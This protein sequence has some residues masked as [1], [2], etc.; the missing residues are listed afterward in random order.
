MIREADLVI[1]NLTDDISVGGSQEMLIAKHYGRLLVGIAPWGGKFRQREKEILGNVYHDWI[2]PFIEVPC[3]V[4][5]E[6]IEEL[7]TW[8]VQQTFPLPPASTLS[9]LDESIQ[10]YLDQYYEHDQYLKTRGL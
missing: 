10:H 4:L 5:F 3:D 9:V 7:A 6:T 2:H 8:I 1:V